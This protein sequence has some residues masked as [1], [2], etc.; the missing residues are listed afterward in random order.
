M[1]RFFPPP[2]PRAQ[3]PFPQ[4]DPLVVHHALGTTAVHHAN[5]VGFFV[6]DREESCPD[7][8]VEAQVFL[9]EPIAVARPALFAGRLT[10]S[11]EPPPPVRTPPGGHAR[12]PTTG[13]P[14]VLRPAPAPL[15]PH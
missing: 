1:G 7:A 3:E 11:V 2:P 10:R 6:C 13:P 4:P 15:Q 8:C 14:P 5:A 12:H 9:L